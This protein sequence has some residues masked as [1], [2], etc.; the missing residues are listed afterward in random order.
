ME[1]L[2]SHFSGIAAKYLTTVETDPEKS[3]QHEF[4]GISSLRKF[5]GEPSEPKRFNAEY[6]YLA[7]DT[8]DIEQVTSSVTWSNVRRNKPERSPEFHMYYYDCPVTEKM[9]VGDLAL[10]CQKKDGTLMII[11]AESGSASVH[12]LKVLFDLDEKLLHKVETK[13]IS[14][15]NKTSTFAEKMILE[16]LGI[17][18]IPAASEYLEE[19]LKLFDNQLPKTAVFSAYAREKAALTEG[20]GPDETLVAWVNKEEEL[21]RAFEKHIVS[22]RL[23]KGFGADNG[24]VDAFV[25]FSLSVHNRRKSRMGKALENH[26]E[27]LLNEIPLKFK[28]GGQT[29]QKKRPDFLF[30]GEKEYANRNFPVNKLIMLGAKSTCKD[31]WRQVLSEAKRIRNK[32]LLTLEPGI[33]E[34]QTSEMHESRLQ[35]VV[36]T[37]IQGT[38]KKSQQSWLMSLTEFIS[39]VSGIQK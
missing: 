25:D 7:D 18:A 14:Q 9:K 5:L 2:S 13:D 35:L 38:Y 22:K 39:F 3:H 24:D 27:I 28:R 32:H 16:S 6:L 21:F 26:L 1:S 37:E 8:D 31:R 34:T 30:P 15:K 23:K 12:Q 19:M 17:Q 4:Q 29:E 20:W 10:F 11:I 36:P 33:S